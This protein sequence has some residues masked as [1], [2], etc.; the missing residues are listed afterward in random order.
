MYLVHAVLGGFVRYLSMNHC[1]A[2]P[3]E[4]VLDCTGNIK[5]FVSMY[6]YVPGCTQ[7]VLGMYSEIPKNECT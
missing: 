6:P 5:T 7:Y 4:Y 2:V 1:S 3:T